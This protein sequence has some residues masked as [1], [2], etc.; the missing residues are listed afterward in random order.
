VTMKRQTLFKDKVWKGK[1]EEVIYQ[2]ALHAFWCQIINL[3]MNKYV[4]N[5]FWKVNKYHVSFS[6]K[7][8]QNMENQ[9]SKYKN[10]C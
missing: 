7:M 8:Q 10:I 6:L 9:N 4:I 1:C 3:Q 5:F 2:S